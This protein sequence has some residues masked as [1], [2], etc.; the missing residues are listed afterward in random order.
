[1]SHDHARPGIDAQRATL[2]TARAVFDG[3][4][5]A[6]HRAAGAASCARCT[7]ISAVQL[8]FAL[9]A[10]MAG[11]RGFVTERT[12]ARLLDAI[13]EAEAELRAAGN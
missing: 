5:E 10:R 6:A 4:P 13:S 12:R 9:G 7:V 3:D 11:D 8:G 1:M 2:A